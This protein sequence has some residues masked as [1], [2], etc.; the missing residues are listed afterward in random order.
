MNLRF[1]LAAL[2][3]VF[4]TAAF[5]FNDGV[6]VTPAIQA[7]AYSSGNA[8]GGTTL[9]VKFKNG[10]IEFKYG[11]KTYRA[12]LGRNGKLTVRTAGGKGYA[13]GTAASRRYREAAFIP[14][15]SPSEA[16]LRWELGRCA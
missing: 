11:G 2:A 3:A 14:V 4:S 10:V 13:S 15:Q 5:A 8:I 9:Y 16:Q 12:T 1:V 7:A 6:S